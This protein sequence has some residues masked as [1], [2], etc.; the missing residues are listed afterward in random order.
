MCHRRV[1]L[2]GE[3]H[4][5]NYEATGGQRATPS[6]GFHGIYDHLDLLRG[7]S[8]PRPIRVSIARS[9]CPN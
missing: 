8:T 3:K 7:Q 6:R 2:E 4:A 1:S 9:F 5:K